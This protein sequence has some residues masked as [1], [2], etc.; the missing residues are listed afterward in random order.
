MKRYLFAGLLAIVSI[1]AWVLFYPRT[2]PSNNNS[3]TA[4][5]PKSNGVQFFII[6]DAVNGDVNLKVEVTDDGKKMRMTMP[7]Y[8]FTYI[9]P[10]TVVYTQKNFNHSYILK[11][12]KSKNDQRVDSRADSA[13][14]PMLNLNDYETDFFPGSEFW[15]AFIF[16]WEAFNAYQHGN[17]KNG[18]NSIESLIEENKKIEVIIANLQKTNINI[19]IFS[20]AVP[21]REVIQ[22]YTEN[23]YMSRPYLGNFDGKNDDRFDELLEEYYQTLAEAKKFKAENAAQD[24]DSEFSKRLRDEQR[25]QDMHNLKEMIS[26]YLG[27]QRNP[28]LCGTDNHRTIY[29]STKLL[30]PIGWELKGSDSR[31]V[32]GSGWIPINFLTSGGGPYLKELPVDPINDSSKKLTYVFVCG[33]EKGKYEINTRMESEKYSGKDMRFNVVAMDGGDNPGIYEEGNS[34]KMDLVPAGLW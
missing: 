17:L 33:F 7:P 26:L 13:P 29:A 8:I 21:F 16:S 10:D 34:V 3:H 30:P 5:I 18:E 23:H 28:T 24:P 19:E 20:D 22:V 9:A 15:A 32:D 27:S 6:H 25:I 11:S 14:F 31:A 1:S 12:E 4:V 2:V